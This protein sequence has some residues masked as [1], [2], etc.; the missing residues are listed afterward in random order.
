MF[1][2]E[3]KKQPNNVVKKIN[4]EKKQLVMIPNDILKYQYVEE[5]G[6]GENNLLFFPKNILMLENITNIK[7]Q[8]NKIK[9]IP[10][11]ISKNKKNI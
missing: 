3:R 4:L 11:D 9:S 1:D 2:E 6:L 7:L 10:K 5:I 8:N